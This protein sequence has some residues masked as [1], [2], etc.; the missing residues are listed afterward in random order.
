MRDFVI[1]LRSIIILWIVTV[2]IYPVLILAIGQ[3]GFSDQ[4]NGSLI[5]NNEG[6]VVGS[7][8]IG[9]TF[10]S[11]Q[12]FWSRPS[13]VS[14][15]EGSDASPTG[16]SG[17]SNLAPDN[18]ELLSRIETEAQRLDNEGVKPIADLLYASGSGLDPH[19]SPAAAR[20]QIERIAN[21]RQISPSEI[22]Q[23]VQQY[24]EGRF[25]GIFGEP[26]VNVLRLNLALDN[27]S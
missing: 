7:A 24:T 27:I 16:I 23:L 18:P 26:G 22:E 4:A 17:A 11:E 21:R 15:S 25:L 19:I 8:I 14:Y 5:T 3:V 13:S 10:T 20:V 2:V 1:S 6:K 12:Y 9:Q